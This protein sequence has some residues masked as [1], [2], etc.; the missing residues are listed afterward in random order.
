VYARAGNDTY[1]FGKGSGK[2]TISAYDGTVGKVD[3]IQLGADLL[4]SDVV[5]KREGDAL[6]LSING[7]TDTLRVSS[8]FSYDAT[9]GYQV[10]QI[11]FADGTIWDVNAV[12]AMV[13]TAT[14]ENDTLYGYASADTLSGLSGDDIVYAR[15]GNDTLDGGAGDDLLYGGD[16]DDIIPGGTQN[17]LLDGG[18][19]SDNLQGQDGND[20]LYGQDGNDTLD[21]GLGND[22]LH[23]GAGNDLINGGVNSDRLT[24]GSGSDNFSYQNPNEGADV[25]TDFNGNSELI[26]LSA[27][28]FGGGLVAGMDLLASGRYVENSTGLATSIAGTGQFI[29]LTSSNQLYWD[30]D[31]EGGLSASL[32]TTF[33][34]PVNWSAS[35]LQVV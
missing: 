21:G 35:S 25:I 27:A 18:A 7:S 24:G 17:D 19:G 26:Q 29:Y 5:L 33:S 13:L 4:S 12:K 34:N 32:L 6:V 20:T 9:Q 8:Y 3:L 14:S 31:G 22:I 28:G 23:G 1:L 30:G 11:K 2:D 15:A 10:E 16:G